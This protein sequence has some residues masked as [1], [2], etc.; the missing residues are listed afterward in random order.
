VALQSRLADAARHRTPGSALGVVSMGVLSALIVGPC[1]AAPLAGALLYIAQ[2]GDAVLGGLALFVMA[3]GMGTPVMVVG[4]FTRQL[5]PR[6]GPWMEGVKRAF[7]VLLLALAVWV[8]QPVL[9][10]PVTLGAW[11]VLLIGTGIALRAIDSLPPKA[12][13]MQRL[14]KACGLIAL[15]TG[16]AMLAGSLAGWQDPLRPLGFLRAHSTTPSLPFERVASVA[17]LESR[18]AKDPRPVML[19]FYA[20]WCITCKEMERDTFSDPAVQ[21]AL[22]PFLLLKADVT[23]H[24]EDDL[25]LLRAFNL[26]GPPAIL[27]FKPGGGEVQGTRVIGFQPPS[28]FLTSI[29]KAQ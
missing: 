5:L 7:G 19:D 23:R 22:R 6:T 13:M 24:T 2:T 11:A 10:G 27:F 8:V 25:A 1:V 16:I 20:D 15:L 26:F 12:S 18:I 17:E 4:V 9:P 21:E 14:A 3:L 29:G 28:E